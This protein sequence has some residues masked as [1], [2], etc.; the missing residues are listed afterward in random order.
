MEQG[1][2]PALDKAVH[3]AGSTQLRRRSSTGVWRQVPAAVQLS[4]AAGGQRAVGRNVATTT[5]TWP[6]LGHRTTAG[7]GEAAEGGPAAA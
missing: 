6:H 3:K 5:M 2:S 1:G 4:A 7:G